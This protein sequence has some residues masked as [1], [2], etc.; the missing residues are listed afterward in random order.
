MWGN[1]FEGCVIEP[2]FYHCLEG[3]VDVWDGGSWGPRFIRQF[4]DLELEDVDTFFGRLH[5]CFSALGTIDDMAWMGTKNEFFSVKI[6]YFSLASRSLE[7]FP[8]ST[9]W[10]SWAPA[11]ASFFVWEA[12]WARILTQDQLRRR[13]WRLPN[14]CYMCKVVEET[15]YHILLHCPKASLLWQLVFALFQV[16]WV[17]HSSVRGVLLSWNS[18]SVDKKRKKAWK[19]ASLCIFWSIWKERNGR[20]FEDRESS[21]QTIQSSFLYIFCDWVRV[22]MGDSVTSLIDFVDWLDST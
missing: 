6:F 10:N 13:G 21:D 9:V 14:R 8:H 19:V 2:L 11:R 16:Q 5:N 12:D 22:Y 1:A 3:L 20:A 15:G 4:N 18:C 7:S 17:M